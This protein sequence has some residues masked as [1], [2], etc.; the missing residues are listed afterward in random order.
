MR[1]KFVIGI[2]G[3]LLAFAAWSANGRAADKKYKI[4]NIVFQD[5]QFMQMV[6]FGARDA[7]RQAGDVDL[8]EGNSNNKLDK[9][10]QLVDAFIV[11]KV[12]ALLLTPLSKKASVQAVKRAKQK[13]LVIITYNSPVDGG[14]EDAHIEC[15][16]RDLGLQTGRVAARYI[17]EKLGGQAKVAILAFKTQV[18]EQSD[19]RTGGFKEALKDL[20]G[21]QIVAEQ[22][23][24]LAEMSV[25]KAGD[26]LTAH[27]DLDIL[28]AANEGGTVGAV[29]AVKNA[30]KAGRVAVFGTDVSE[31]MLGF[32]KSDDNILQAM[33][34]QRPFEAGQQAVQTALKLLRH[35]PTEKR[36]MMKGVCL[37]RSEPDQILAYE[38]QLKEWVAQGK[39]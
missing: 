17:R 25:K 22:D 19:A 31:Q 35:Q 2:C 37:S 27:P 33:T 29:L 1:T 14:Y 34:A 12:D 13:G 26:I 11:A 38:K 21:V 23:A 20:P 3:A 24:W 28:W 39:L 30:G 9:E 6:L 32:A 7:A 10:K 18:P 5:D 36:I 4:A 8:R 15:D 16:P